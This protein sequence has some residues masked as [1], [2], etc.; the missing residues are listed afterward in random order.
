MV[1]GD[2]RSCNVALVVPE[3]PA[4]RA[5]AAEHAIGGDGGDTGAPLR[6]P[7]LLAE[8]AGDIDRLSP[9]FRGYERI[10]AFVLLPEPFTQAN[11]MLTPS[12]K[13]KRRKIVERWRDEIER[14]YQGMADQD[15]GDATTTSA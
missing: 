5:W 9:G 13:L 7:L 15:G 4:V 3:L 14:M 1:F 6:D 11:G 12:L 10:A 2:N 8:V